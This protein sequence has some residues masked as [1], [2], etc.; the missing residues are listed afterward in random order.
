MPYTWAAAT[1]TSATTLTVTCPQAWISSGTTLTPL[2][3]GTG[4]TTWQTPAGVQWDWTWTITQPAWQYPQYRPETAAQRAAR[5][6]R[7]ADWRRRHAEQQAA[8][9]RVTERAEKLLLS[10]LTADQAASY[11][12]DGWFE[13]TGSAGGRFRINRRGQAGNIDELPADGGPRIASYCI[14]PSGGFPDADAQ[15]AQYLML[16]TDEP[17]FRRTANRT[18]RYRLPAA[19]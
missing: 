1:S 14:H 10:L 19:A 13:V 9:V 12:R 8:R 7:D 16:V 2:L 4:S 5:E 6:Q 11:L 3:Y 15:A 17:G 18:P